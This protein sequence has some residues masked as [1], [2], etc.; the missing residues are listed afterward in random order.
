MSWT[1]PKCE[2]S[3]ANKNQYHICSTGD[4]WELFE[5]RPD[6]VLLA[7][8]TLMSTVLEWE[9]CEVSKAKTTAVFSNGRKAWLIVRPMKS[10]LDIWFYHSEELDHP[11]LHRIKPFGKRFAH[12]VRVSDEVQLTREVLDLLRIGYDFALG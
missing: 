6:E 9:P 3:F 2:R 8:D 11:S 1:C 12:H 5:G 4:V 7:F 10:Q